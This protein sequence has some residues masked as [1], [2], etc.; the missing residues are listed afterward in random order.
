MLRIRLGGQNTVALKYNKLNL[1][2]TLK[3]VN[4]QPQRWASSHLSGLIY[5]SEPAA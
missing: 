4:F 5:R 2:N 1:G 3:T